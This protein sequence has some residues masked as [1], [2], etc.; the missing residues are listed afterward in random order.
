MADSNSQPQFYFAQINFLPHKPYSWNILK[1]IRSMANWWIYAAKY[2]F[3][4]SKM[5]FENANPL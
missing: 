3:Y 2:V 4:T 5:I 1:L